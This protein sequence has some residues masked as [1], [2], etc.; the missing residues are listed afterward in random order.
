MFRNNFCECVL[1]IFGALPPV[2]TTSETEMNT[3]TEFDRRP[4]E[5]P[6]SNVMASTSSSPNLKRV[7]RESGEYDTI[8]E[9]AEYA[10]SECDICYHSHQK[11]IYLD[12]CKKSKFLCI[13]CFISTM[14]IRYAK[15]Y[16]FP[17]L[18]FIEQDVS[19]TF[20][21]YIV[22]PFC[23]QNCKLKNNELVSLEIKKI[24]NK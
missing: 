7:N 21:Y 16:N 5:I 20:K 23:T 14:L 22:C 17:V 24:I 1:S 18:T 9:C 2:E 13:H 4:N 6:Q 10:I 15:E 11:G 8:H 19:L 3:R 12:C